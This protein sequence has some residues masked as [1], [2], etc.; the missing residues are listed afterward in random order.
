MLRRQQIKGLQPMPRPGDAQY[1]R[2]KAVDL[3]RLAVWCR[4][5]TAGKLR[6]CANEIEEM[7]AEM[8]VLRD[9]SAATRP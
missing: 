7:A 2:E 8:D 4:E 6:D 9:T 1:L 3:R 5:L